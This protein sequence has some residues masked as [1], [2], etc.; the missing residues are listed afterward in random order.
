MKSRIPLDIQAISVKI[1]LK[2]LIVLTFLLVL[3]QVLKSVLE[4]LPNPALKRVTI[5]FE[6][7][8][9]IRL[10]PSRSW[11]DLT[12]THCIAGRPDDLPSLH[13][14]LRHDIISPQFFVA[15]KSEKSGDWERVCVWIVLRELL[16]NVEIRGCVFHWTQALWRKV[17]QETGK[18]VHI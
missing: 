13:H 3:L 15:L 7:A 4:L 9:W 5:D 1:K 17:S 2:H 12:R 16:P 14:N 18:L 11:G 8:V 10:V 6:K